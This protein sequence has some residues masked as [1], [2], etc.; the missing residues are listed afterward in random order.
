MN[1][2]ILLI[3][4]VLFAAYA[5]AQTCGT[6]ASSVSG[7][8]LCNQGY[9]GTSAAQGQTCTQCPTGT[10]TAAPSTTSNTMAGADVSACTQC[11]ANYQ[12][13]AVAAAAAAPAPA[14]AATCVACPNNSGNTGATVVG[15]LS[16]CN[17]CKAGYYQT[18]AAS[19]GVASACQQCPSGTSVAGSTSSTACTSSTTSSKMLFASLAILITSL[20]A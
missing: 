7:T 17:I 14:A 3:A 13:T 18:T 8:C 2:S 10:T 1:K 12:M 11:S 20:L 16:Q 15:D 6:N 5:N 4:F 9:Y 19:T